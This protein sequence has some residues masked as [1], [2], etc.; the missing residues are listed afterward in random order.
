MSQ[1]SS[2]RKLTSTIKFI[3]HPKIYII[4]LITAIF[5]L[6]YFYASFIGHSVSLTYHLQFSLSQCGETVPPNEVRSTI[7]TAFYDDI[8]PYQDFPPAH[9]AHLL[10]P[11]RLEGWG[12]KDVVFANLIEKTRP[13]T[14]LEIG[15]FLGASATHMA[16]LTRGLKLETQIL[17]LDDFRGWAGFRGNFKSFPIQNG[18][19]MLL[20]QFMQNVITLNLSE[21]IIP[22][23]FSTS[24]GLD[25][26]CKLGILADLIEIDAAHD[27]HSVW[28]DI[29]RA[30]RL[31]RPGGV[32]F[33]H[34]YFNLVDDYGVK[35]AVDL[36]AKLH[37]FKVTTSKQH[38]IIDVFA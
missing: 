5:T 15:T 20:Q 4:L 1:Y 3:N 12:S 9:L 33:G 2:T 10:K 19:V 27:F 38:W 31:L 34:D 23:P 37:G 17:C 16:N 18:N 28:D 32:M 25:R 13:Q 30:Y 8:S 26:L 36:F 14:I 6:G 24:S 7:L 22:V 35:R 11:K 21:T 29:N